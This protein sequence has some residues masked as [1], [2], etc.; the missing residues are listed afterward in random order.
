MG[1]DTAG[2]DVLVAGCGPVGGVLAALLGAYGV[3][4][5]VVDPYTEP[6]PRPRAA[7]LDAGVRRILRR[8]PG[9]ADVEGW[10]TPVRHGRVLGPDHRVLFDARI[11]G[12]ELDPPAA[13]LIDQPRLE[14]AVRASLSAAPTVR[15]RLGR[16]VVGVEQTDEHVEALLDDGGRVRANWLVGC[17]GA[18]SAVRGLLGVA[19]EGVSFPEPWLVVDAS[20]A[21]I[22]DAEPSFAYVLDPARPLVTMSRV[23]AH[24]WE[25]LVLPG[26]DPAT[27]VQDGEI[28]RLVGAWVDPDSV[29]IRRASVFTFHARMASRWRTGRVLLA[30]DAAHSMPPFVGQGLGS[31]IRDAANLSW[32]LAQVVRGVDDPVSLDGYERER[33]PDVRATTAMALRMGR[34]VQNRGRVGSALLRSLIRTA[35]AVPGLAAFVGRHGQPAERL[36]RGTAGRHPGAGRLL[37]DARLRTPTGTVLRLDDLLGNRWAVIGYGGDPYWH[38][39]AGARRWVSDRDAMVFA[40][41]PRGRRSPKGLD[42]PV[43]EDLDGVLSRPRRQAVTIVRPDRFLLGTLPVPL[44]VARL[45]AP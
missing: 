35:G 11:P 10:A 25:W 4:V 37:P 7:M 24:R 3:R 30:G 8:V 12:D 23:G 1:L 36:P 43:F 27:M 18:A 38:L 39:D 44:S 15:L 45:T 34:I 21:P 40:L 33:R 41:V 32:R 16:S 6:Y 28:R 31:G 20:S 9:L 26:E 13:V 29:R 5:L 2:V 22:P 42:C 19:Y 14:T 17:D